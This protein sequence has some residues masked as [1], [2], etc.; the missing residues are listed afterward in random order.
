MA[1]SSGIRSNLREGRQSR[2]SHQ[3]PASAVLRTSDGGFSAYSRRLFA[4]I[5]R[6][7]DAGRRQFDWHVWRGPLAGARGGARRADAFA[8]AQPTRAARVARRRRDGGRLRRRSRRSSRPGRGRPAACR[9]LRCV[10]AVVALA[11][12]SMAEFEIGRGAG[13]P[14][15]LV[16]VPVL[17]LLAHGPRA[18]LVMAA[19]VLERLAHRDWRTRILR[20]HI[21]IGS[22]WFSLGP[23]ARAA[24]RGRRPAELVALAGLR[25][26]LRRAD[27]H[28]S[29]D[30]RDQRV[31]RVRAVADHD[32][33]TR[34]PRPASS[35]PRCR[36]PGSRS[37][38]RDA[39]R[40]A[41]RCSRDCR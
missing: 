33:G 9:S 11:L 13:V 35:T 27:R 32:R 22:C 20:L 16:F 26:R 31:A 18:V 4:P 41:T 15:Q 7:G 12:A 25:P 36:R 37:R 34:R 5:P 39:A 29:R 24:G 23:D 30:E 1:W 19:Y 38:S 40:S 2:L 21:T 10:V 28:R 6:K 3:C 17:F 14:T 8:L